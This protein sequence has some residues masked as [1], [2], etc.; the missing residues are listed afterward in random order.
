MRKTYRGG[1][2][3]AHGKS[4]FISFNPGWGEPGE[5]GITFVNDELGK[6]EGGLTLDAAEAFSSQ[7]KYWDSMSYG[8]ERNP[9]HFENYNWATEV[10]NY[11]DVIR[12]G[13]EYTGYDDEALAQDLALQDRML[14]AIKHG[15]DDLSN[16]PI[17]IADFDSLA[18]KAEELARFIKQMSDE[19]HSLEACIA[20]YRA[21]KDGKPVGCG[22]TA[23]TLES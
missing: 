7:Q 17:D 2:I 11:E 13:L 20:V 8:R 10:G 3:H 22:W 9:A 16:G 15:V 5:W 1:V 21:L 14:A 19:W 18:T 4:A 6:T 23:A 12:M